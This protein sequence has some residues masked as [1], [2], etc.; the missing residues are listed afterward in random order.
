MGNMGMAISEYADKL[1]RMDRVS[2]NMVDFDGVVDLTDRDESVGTGDYGAVPT[3]SY[4]CSVDDADWVYTQ[5]D[6]K[7]PAG[8]PGLNVRFRVS[9]DEPERRGIKVANQ[10]FFK[11]YWVPPKD[12]DKEAAQ[13]LRGAL[14]NFL[15]AAGVTDEKL[16]SK[17]FNLNDEKDEII[18]NPLTVVVGKKYNEV[19]ETDEN[20]VMGVKPAGSSTSRERAGSVL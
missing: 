3:G 9:L 17:K 12:H 7:M 14:T 5:N 16:N 8:T 13:K 18:G 15:K 1:E 20:P 10:C 2:D 6:G 4:Q 11:T 19:K